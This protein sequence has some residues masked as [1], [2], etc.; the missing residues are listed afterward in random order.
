MPQ[1]VNRGAARE[2]ALGRAAESVQKGNPG[3]F[4]CRATVDTISPISKR[5]V[6]LILMLSSA[7]E[8]PSATM[9]VKVWGLECLC[10]L[11]GRLDLTEEQFLAALDS[12]ELGDMVGSIADDQAFIMRIRVCRS[13]F[14][15]TWEAH[16]NH[17]TRA[18]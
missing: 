4:S 9:E 12:D 18:P 1:L 17:V 3:L 15:G 14:N 11:F 6:G 8:I 16:V 13:S 10:A 2:V 7:S 5:A